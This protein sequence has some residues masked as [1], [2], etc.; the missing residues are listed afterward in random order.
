MMNDLQP[1]MAAVPALGADTDTVLE[2][3]GYTKPEIAG[4]RKEGAI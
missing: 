1:R 4:L 3:I 2:E